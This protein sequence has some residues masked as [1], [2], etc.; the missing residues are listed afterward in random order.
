MREYPKKK[1]SKRLLKMAFQHDRV[2]G[3]HKWEPCAWDKYGK[4]HG[5]K[6]VS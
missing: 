6:A 5:L 2:H 1:P 3:P 4:C